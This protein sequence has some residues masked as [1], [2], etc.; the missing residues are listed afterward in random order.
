MYR[1]KKWVVFFKKEDIFTK[2]LMLFVLT[3]Q[4]QVLNVRVGVTGGKNGADYV[5]NLQITPTD[6][7]NGS[8]CF[9]TSILQSSI[10]TYVGAASSISF[11][12][13][14]GTS[15]ITLSASPVGAG[16]VIQSITFDSSTTVGVRSATLTSGT[17][18]TSQ[19]TITATDKNNVITASTFTVV[20][21]PAVS[22]SSISN[23]NVIS[24]TSS[25]TIPVF[26][27]GGN[28]TT[29]SMNVS[30][31]YSSLI[32]AILV[33]SNIQL[34]ASNFAGSATITVF[35]IDLMGNHATKSFIATVGMTFIHFV[36]FCL[37]LLF[38]LLLF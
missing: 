33:G 10:Y 34:S 17:S 13:S 22:I 7:L 15:P 11:S 37:L 29:Y 31:S 1:E 35:A 38:L 12:L 25:T 28:G 20:V 14:G 8:I 26:V 32:T 6:C 21:Y 3:A 2:I 4:N 5:L 9:N 24:S 27:S 18:G 36:C 16:N 23:V 30:S 19:I